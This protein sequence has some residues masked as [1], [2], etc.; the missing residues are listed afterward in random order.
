MYSTPSDLAKLIDERTLLQLADDS[1]LAGLDDERVQAVLAEA[2][3]QADREIDSY[4]CMALPV[5]LFPVPDLVANLSAKIAAY[6]LFRRRPHLEL[7]EWGKEYDRCLRLLERIAQRKVVLES[8]DAE[9]AQAEPDSGVSVS[10]PA[11]HFGGRLW[12]EY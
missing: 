4:V 12:E 5:P 7:G 11:A 8:P 1:G 2:I 6:N 3:E 10:A 9:P